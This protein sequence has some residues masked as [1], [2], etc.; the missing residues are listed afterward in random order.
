MIYFVHSWSFYSM[1][2][3]VHSWSFY[4]HDIFCT[5]LIL[6]QHDIFC[7]Q[8]ILLQH[9][10]VTLYMVRAHTHIRVWAALNLVTLRFMLTFGGNIFP[11]FNFLRKLPKKKLGIF[12]YLTRLYFQHVIFFFFFTVVPSILILSKFYRQL[13][14]KRTAQ[15]GVLKFILK[16]LQHVSM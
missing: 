5:Q 4:R 11:S 14:H 15:K 7:T 1:I 6:L 3:F 10:K 8:L 13:M 9:D 12:M 2:Y 16:Q